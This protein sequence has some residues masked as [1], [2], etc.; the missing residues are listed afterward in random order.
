MIGENPVGA[1]KVSTLN[2]S[3]NRLTKYGARSLA[4]ALAINRSLIRLDLSKC[5]LQEIGVKYIC[6]GA[7]LFNSTLRWLSLYRNIFGV[8]G[9]RAIGKALSKNKALEFLDIGHNRI[10]QTG[11]KA[12]CDGILENP[13]SKLQRLGLRSNF[14]NDEGFTNFFEK[15]VLPKDGSRLTQIFIKFN[16]LSEFQKINLARQVKDILFVDDFQR[17]DLLDK[18]HLDLS[19]WVSPVKSE[20]LTQTETME[21]T[22]TDRFQCG[23]ITD[24]RM[25]IGR[26]AAGRKRDNNFCFV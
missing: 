22:L 8:E 7:L 20:T 5:H 1:C 24:I 18:S 17:A 4:P 2:L 6:E 11:L 12:I 10:R 3:R 21:A 26:K 23:L 15:L 25:R 16:L 19:I 14:I 13:G 9:A